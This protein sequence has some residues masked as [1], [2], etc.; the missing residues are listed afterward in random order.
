MLVECIGAFRDGEAVL[1]PCGQYNLFCCG[2]NRAARACC[3][4]E[5]STET[6]TS[7]ELM[8]DNMTVITATVT[9]TVRLD[10][11]R[12]NAVSENNEG[13]R[14]SLKKRDNTVI[15]L[16]VVLG[17]VALA[18]AFFLWSWWKRGQRLKEPGRRRVAA[19]EKPSVL[20]QS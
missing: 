9:E 14:A 13:L 11:E 6:I 5:N 15:A 19:R 16:G 2:Q 20:S 7:G 10:P 4:T 3:D 8:L 18:L 12:T 1:T 17:V